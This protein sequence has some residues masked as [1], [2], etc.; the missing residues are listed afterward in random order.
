MGLVG[1]FILCIIFAVITGNDD[2]LSGLLTLGVGIL[3]IVGAFALNPVLGIIAL[4]VII[5]GWK[6]M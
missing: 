1:F 3:I 4:I 2:C 5:N 6:K